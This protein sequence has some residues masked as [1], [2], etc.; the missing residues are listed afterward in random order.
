MIYKAIILAAGHGKRMGD[1]CAKIPKPMLLIENKPIIEHTIQELFKCGIK[2]IGINTFYHSNIIE[3]YIQEQSYSNVITL[4]K[5]DKLSGTAGA[6]TLFKDFLKEDENFIVI[7]GDILTDFDY[8]RLINFHLQNSAL[9]T[10][11]YHERSQ[12]NSYLEILN[13][14][15][16]GEVSFFSERPNKEEIKKI[17]LSTWKINSSIYCFNQEVL[18]LIPPQEESDIPRDLFPKLLKE[19]RLFTLPLQAN[20]WA[21]DS[22]ERLEKARKEFINRDSI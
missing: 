4:I 7:A 21:I 13:Q 9:G 11:A 18:N 12:S 2:E 16:E 14:R 10:F 22:P 17:N 1:L 15:K 6:L 8:K 19:K 5:E 20:R 3:K